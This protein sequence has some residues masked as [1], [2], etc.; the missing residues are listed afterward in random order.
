LHRSERPLWANRVT[1]R[2]E[3][4]ASLFAASYDHPIAR[5]LPRTD[6]IHHIM[7]GHRTLQQKLSEICANEAREKAA[8]ATTTSASAA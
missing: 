7:S 5:L 3:K 1:L 4:T 8:K 2:C 6:A